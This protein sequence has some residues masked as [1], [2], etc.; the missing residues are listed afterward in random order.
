M[1]WAQPAKTGLGP[2]AATPFVLTLAPVFTLL[3]QHLQS[4]GANP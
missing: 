2:V 3:C 1:H 4:R